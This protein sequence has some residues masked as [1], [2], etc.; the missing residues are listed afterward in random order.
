MQLIPP[1]QILNETSISNADA[2]NQI[3]K[4]SQ[5]DTSKN[6]GIP[7]P[8]SENSIA[9][10][11]ATNKTTGQQI[12]N[13]KDNMNF[14]GEGYYPIMTAP[15]QRTDNFLFNARNNLPTGFQR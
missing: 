7:K 6:K 11:N 8:K 14:T 12:E 5:V 3:V 2:Y 15:Y 4:L 13:A 9:I 1:P 10:V